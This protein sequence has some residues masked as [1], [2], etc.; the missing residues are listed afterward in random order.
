MAVVW[1]EV[2]GARNGPAEASKTNEGLKG[3]R[4]E[5]GLRCLTRRA[6]T[7]RRVSA[8]FAVASNGWLGSEPLGQAATPSGTSNFCGYFDSIQAERK[9]ASGSPSIV[10][11]TSM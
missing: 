4:M 6:S 11:L 9:M 1:M 8:A 7:C 10:G 3:G 5:A 2:Y